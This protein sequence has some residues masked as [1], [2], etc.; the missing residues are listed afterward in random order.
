MRALEAAWPTW[1]ARC[2]C[3]GISGRAQCE[4]MRLLG[5]SGARATR[6]SI[7]RPGQF[8]KGKVRYDAS[9]NRKQLGKTT[10]KQNWKINKWHKSRD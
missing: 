4:L 10:K 8:R 9:K 3:P 6:R 2:T 5:N 1:T 7:R